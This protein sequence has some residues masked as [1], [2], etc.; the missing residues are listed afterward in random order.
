MLA[1]SKVSQYEKQIGNVRL[2]R[3]GQAVNFKFKLML[4][5]FKQTWLQNEFL[6]PTN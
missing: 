3:I 4:Y 5:F 6:I 2:S 1:G